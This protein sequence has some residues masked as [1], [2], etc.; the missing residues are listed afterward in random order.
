[1]T[2]FGTSPPDRG[3]AQ[4]R[5]GSI[6]RRDRKKLLPRAG[7]SGRVVGVKVKVDRR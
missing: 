1:V 6:V 7:R 4:R 2:N 5:H 3:R